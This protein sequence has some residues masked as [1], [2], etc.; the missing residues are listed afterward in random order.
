MSS[1]SA[2]LNPDLVDTGSPPIPQAQGWARAYD[3][4]FGPLIDLSQ[5]V[6]GAP[7]PQALLDRLAEAAA[8][9]ASTRYGPITGKFV[10]YRG[11]SQEIDDI[12]YQNVEEYLRSLA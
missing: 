3:G 5:A 4:R 8:D 12:Q 10:L 6:P 2:F 7:P 1:A 9:P 11:E